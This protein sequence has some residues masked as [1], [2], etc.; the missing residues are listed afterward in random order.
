MHR[1][2]LKA[3][4][5]WDD[6]S[7]CR[8]RC[9]NSDNVRSDVNSNNGGRRWLWIDCY[10]TFRVVEVIIQ[11]GCISLDKR[12]YPESMARMGSV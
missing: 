9:R 12:I 4:G 5:N 2:V 7:H 8:S 10:K 1:Y 3:G 11:N 6:S